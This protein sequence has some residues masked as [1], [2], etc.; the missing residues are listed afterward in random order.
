MRSNQD[1]SPQS[2]NRLLS[3]QFEDFAI[4]VPALAPK[5]PDKAVHASTNVPFSGLVA[6]WFNHNPEPA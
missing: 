6:N 1:S 5:A 2:E 4:A 3:S